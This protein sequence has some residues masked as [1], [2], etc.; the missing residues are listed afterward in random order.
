[1]RKAAPEDFIGKT[2]KH[3]NCECDNVVHLIF[4][5][6]TTLDVWAEDIFVGGLDSL[7]LIQ[8]VQGVYSYD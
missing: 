2:I 1:M 5:D 8:V 7:P 3:A 4:T 6:D